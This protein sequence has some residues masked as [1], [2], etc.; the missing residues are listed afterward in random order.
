MQK[1][2]REM[3]DLEIKAVARK[4]IASSSSEEEV[5]CRIAAELGCPYG[6]AL[7]SHVPTDEIGYE[8]RTIVRGL[9]GLVMK[10]GA[11]AMAMLFGPKGNTIS[12]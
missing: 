4:I 1:P 10:N 7:T 3:S 2:Y 11:M 9:G 5:K 8:A 6:I 12:V